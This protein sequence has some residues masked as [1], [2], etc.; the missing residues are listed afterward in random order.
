M[1]LALLTRAYSRK[2]GRSWSKKGDQQVAYEK[3]N[4][5]QVGDGGKKIIWNDG[6]WKAGSGKGEEEQN[7]SLF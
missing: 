6:K 7:L 4:V 5:D 3:K 1:R 2:E